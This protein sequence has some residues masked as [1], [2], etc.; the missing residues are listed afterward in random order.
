[1]PRVLLLL[2]TSSWRAEALLTACTRLGLEVTV[3]A[4]RP[5]VWAE[6]IPAAVLA[7]DFARPE[8]AAETVAAFARDHP[9][10]AVIGADDETGVLAA[11]IAGRLDLPHNPI[12][13]LAAVRDK[14][15]QRERLAAGSIPVPR[16]TLAR[17]DEDPAALA[18]RIEFP[19][20]VKP[21]RLS[22][23][24]GVMRADESLGLGHALGRLAAL[25]ALPEVGACGA[26]GDGREWAETAVVE[27]FVPGREVALEGLIEDGM[28]R[29]LALFDKPDP[30][31]GPCFEETIYVTPSRLPAPMQRAVADC[32]ARAA[33]ALGLE[34]GPVHAELR[35]NEQGPWLIELAAR[36]IGGLC[37]QTLRFGDGVP[38]E[39]LLVMEALGMETRGLVRERPSAGVMMLPIPG[40][41]T[42]ERVEGQA[43]AG[44]VP[45]VERVVITAHP[46]ERMTPFPE[47]SR[48]PGFVFARGD[49]PA[50]VEQALREAARRLRFVLAP[51]AAPPPATVTAAVASGR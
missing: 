10:A 12:T 40:A 28:L 22:G 9:L 42:L 20:V 41:G 14:H 49:D 16:F 34:R 13:A 32:A 23:S 3:G 50:T 30:L 17:L 25:L 6:R 38:L 1:M 24:R 29:V 21:R 51:P 2:P 11:V 5:L 39:E 44:R 37:S 7:L 15:A 47:G 4:D 8:L 45:H 36:P 31:D 48:Y 18:R 26:S 46:G 43:E 35:V 19:C 33:H 27:A